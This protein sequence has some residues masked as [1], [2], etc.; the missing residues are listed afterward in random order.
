MKKLICL[1]VLAAALSP[2]FAK[3]K[4]ESYPGHQIGAS[5]SMFSGVGMSYQYI[6]NSK[7]RVK[8]TCFVYYY[9]DGG[10]K[11]AWGSVGAEFQYN[12]RNYEET[13]FYLLFGLSRYYYEYEWGGSDKYTDIER[14]WAM[15]PGFGFEVL[16]LEHLALNA[17]VG[18]N[19]AYENNSDYSYYYYENDPYIDNDISRT[20]MIGFG[21]GIY[22]KF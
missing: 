16:L 8:A 19:F 15:G 9:D 10:D 11:D 12:V 7:T 4:K 6:I 17:E 5:A 18:F 3:E 2:A 21:V 22:Y 1:I 14:T 13:R 20:Y